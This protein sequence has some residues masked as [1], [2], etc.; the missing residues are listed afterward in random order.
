ML[1]E[2]HLDGVR[3]DRISIDRIATMRDQTKLPVD[4]V[5]DDLSRTGC[6]L[7]LDREMPTGALVTIGISG[8]GVRHAR[9]SRANH[10]QYACAF[11]T[12][13]NGANIAS[14]ISAETLVADVFHSASEEAVRLVAF[15]GP[16][17]VRKLPIGARA[18]I[19]IGG[20]AVLWSMI[21]AAVVVSTR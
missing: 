14:A 13:I 4:A 17:I 11:I 6:L 7:T 9:I 10:P 18:I 3:C 21:I 16:P 2:A 8:I 5:V 19:I 15:D 1:P 20:S 12:P